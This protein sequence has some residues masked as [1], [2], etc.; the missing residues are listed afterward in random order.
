MLLTAALLPS[1]AAVP[2]AQAGP[3]P[4][5]DARL[6][7]VQHNTDHVPEAWD[8]VVKQVEESDPGLVTVQEVCRPWFEELRAEHPGWTFAYHPRKRH[9]GNSKNP[10]CGG[11]FIGEL[12]IYTGAAHRPT[13]TPDY[14]NNNADGVERFGMACVEFRRAGIPV[15]GCST[16]LSAFPT[17][18]GRGTQPERAAQVQAIMDVTESYR[19]RGWAVVVGGD[20]NMTSAPDNPKQ[21]PDMNIVLGPEVGGTGDFYDGAQHDCAC[22]LTEP[23]TDK[24]NR[25]DY[26]LWSSGRTPF[27]GSA[28]MR[29]LD[30]PAGHHLLVS[31]GSLAR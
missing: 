9:F 21:A 26:V 12:A 20:L 4:A 6:E 16:H 24:G 1:A 31:V 30:S 11:D 13:M 14:P 5:A 22:R 28:S 25:I 19:E 3:A 23:T 17:S 8:F 15:L 27:A 18:G 10:G 29:R 2:A 7:V